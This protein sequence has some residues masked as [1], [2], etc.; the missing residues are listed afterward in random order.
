VNPRSARR[1][2]T[3]PAAFL[4]ALI[5]A[6]PTEAAQ[7][8]RVPGESPTISDAIS[9]A[10][11]GDTV[12][13]AA[14]TYAGP[15]FTDVQL[16]GQEIVIRSEAGSAGTVLDGLA[17][18]RAGFFASG[19]PAAAV[20]IDGF[21]FRGGRS[22]SGGALF[23]G[24]SDAGF[25]ATI[26]NCIFEDCVASGNGG[27]I[28]S[29][30][31]STN[32]WS[33]TFRLANTAQR[34]G[35]AY[36]DGTVSIQDCTFDGCR[37]LLE[38][39]GAVYVRSPDPVSITGSAFTNNRVDESPT[40]NDSGGGVYFEAPFPAVA[41]A[42]SIEGCRFE[43]NVAATSGGAV[44][45]LRS[46]DVRACTFTGNRTNGGGLGGA[47]YIVGEGV[48]ELVSSEFKGN[49]AF[50]AGGLFLTGV[51]SYTIA[52]C[53]FVDNVSTSADGTA[54]GGALYAAANTTVSG[55]TLVRNEASL[56]SGILIGAGVGSVSVDR[57]II[58]L[59]AGGAAVQ[60]SEFS[61]PGSLA[62]SCCDLFGNAGGDYV[63]CVADQAGLNDNI[64]APPGFCDLPG[65][66]FAVTAQSPCAPG[67]SPCGQLIGVAYSNDCVTAVEAA[68]W[69]SI[70]ARYRK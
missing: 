19:H 69:A 5:A 17:S 59:G 33:C 57:T 67:N 45:S 15:G 36:L 58:A 70:K 52:G 11:A 9:I 49:S 8:I 4:L 6:L 46:V 13:V 50:G 48:A 20:T 55:C 26:R 16:D 23:L 37:A 68:S 66:A 28:L 54:G 60:C 64:D 25:A 14:G 7:T 3:R 47:A 44:F 10:A 30:G 42:A 34:G 22:D 32:I 51:G 24:A 29:E 38:K 65:R 21:T 62:L 43:G 31:G 18:T 39:G 12:L 56:G 40:A 41:S 27:A 53:L 63:D 61:L 2:P 35:A 1:S